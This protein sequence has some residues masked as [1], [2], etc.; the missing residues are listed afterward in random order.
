MEKF[1]LIPFLDSITL[2]HTVAGNWLDEVK[3]AAQKGGRH[4]VA[5]AGGRI[6]RWFLEAA[7]E[8][9]KAR[10]VTFEHVDFFWGDERCVPPT[11][12]DSNFALAENY[13]LKKISVPQKNIHRIRGEE[14][15]AKAVQQAEVELRQ[16]VKKN[17]EKLPVLEVIFLGMGEDG[18]VASL[19]PS[20]SQETRSNKA[21]YRAVVGPKP[22]PNRVTLGYSTIAAAKEVWV[23]ASGEGK[24]DALRESISPKGQTPLSQVIQMRPHT[25]LFSDVRV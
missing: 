20:E 6:T 3:R 11:D 16:F 15:P 23:L 22:P 21:V 4:S 17:S 2:A 18:H 9:A 5:L 12:G 13:L 25:K 24:K 7:A 19:F 8:L 14:N 1:E 10:G